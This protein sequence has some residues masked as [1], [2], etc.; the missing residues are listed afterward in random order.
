MSQ[1]DLDLSYYEGKKATPYDIAMQLPVRRLH[2]EQ[3]IED[4]IQNNRITV[5]KAPSGQGKTTLALQVSF[6]LQI[7]YTVY[8]LLWCNDA[9]ELGN[10]IQYFKSRVKLGEKP[11]ILIDNLDS[12]LSEWNRL[13]QL[14]Q[15]EVSYHYKLLITTREDDWYRYSGDLSNVKSIKVIKLALEE[16]EAEKIY[17]VLKRANKLHPSISNWRKAWAK[18]AEKS[19]LL[20]TFTFLRTV[21]CY[22]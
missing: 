17:E 18:V 1:V 20:N 7:E 8:Q 3:E 4:A 19:C 5:I 15:E 21:R 16:K 6:N 22:L 13:A 9:K 2:L 11:L 14:L 10:I 12:Q